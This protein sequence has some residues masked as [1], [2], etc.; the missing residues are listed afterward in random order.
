MLGIGRPT[1]VD[2]E[3]SIIKDAILLPNSIERL[4]K[5]KNERISAFAN[6]PVNQVLIQ[7]YA[8]QFN[9]ERGPL[10]AY[11]L[12]DTYR[13]HAAG[14]ESTAPRGGVE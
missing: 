1:Q 6:D 3:V 4:K 5:D 8:D 11:A 10:A 13:V 12:H 9:T 14:F 7:Q 2:D